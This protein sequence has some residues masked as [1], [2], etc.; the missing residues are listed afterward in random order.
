MSTPDTERE[1]NTVT[2]W[3][4][5]PVE[6]LP[7]ED[8]LKVV[9]WCGEEIKKLRTDRE[10]WKASG[11][12]LGYLMAG[13]QAAKADAREQP[14]SDFQKWSVLAYRALDTAGTVLADVEPESTEEADNL[15]SLKLTIKELCYQALVLNGVLTRNQMDRKF[16]F[17]ALDTDS[18]I[19]QAVSEQPLKDL[20]EVGKVVQPDAEIDGHTWT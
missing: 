18:L 9:A 1:L 3:F 17:N 13:G 8:L 5:Q 15:Q 7:R 6:E 10:R 20:H 12:S 11:S 4:G 19:R 16:H 2:T 14:P